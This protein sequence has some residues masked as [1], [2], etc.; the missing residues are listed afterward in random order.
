MEVETYH[1]KFSKVWGV[2]DIIHLSVH[3][4]KVANLLVNSQ[5]IN[6]HSGRK[7]LM[8]HQEET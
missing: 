3:F 6:S 2:G 7:C 8:S 4:E 5:L 1:W